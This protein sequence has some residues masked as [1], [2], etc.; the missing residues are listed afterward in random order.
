MLFNFN[1]L[2]P[3]TTERSVSQPVV[4]FGTVKPKPAPL[5]FLFGGTAQGN[6]N[7][8]D[9]HLTLVQPTIYQDNRDEKL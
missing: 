6:R 7:L 2:Q 9:T 3:S 1:G 5:N 8:M 4:S